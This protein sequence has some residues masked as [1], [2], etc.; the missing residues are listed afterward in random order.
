[1]SLS[2][3]R[4]RIVTRLGLTL[5]FIVV[6]TLSAVA[7][8]AKKL[9]DT[10]QLLTRL[11]QREWQVSVLAASWQGNAQ[12]ISARVSASMRLPAGA[13]RDSFLE[14]TEASD[15]AVQGL[16]KAL[17]PLV[18]DPLMRQRLA[19]A[20]LAS[21][22]FQ[23]IRA[24]LED[25][26]RTGEY[27]A[28]DSMLN[29][30]FEVRRK[31]YVEAIDQLRSRALESSQRATEQA[32]ADTQFAALVA[33]VW[34][35]FCVTSAGLAAWL[36][37]RS[38]KRP[39]LD[40]VSQAQAMAKGDLSGQPSLEFGGETGEVEAALHSMRLSLRDLVAQLKSSTDLV[41]LAIADASGHAVNAQQGH[42]DDAPGQ[43][44]VAAMASS[45]H[46]LQ[47]S[48]QT[49]AEI[50]WVKNNA[51]EVSRALQAK[52][53]E[54]SYGQA[55]VDRL[56]PVLQVPLAAFYLL[57]SASQQWQLMGRYGLN[58][59]D[60]QTLQIA[61]GEGPVGQCGRDRTAIDLDGLAPEH[62]RLR[63]ALLESV[64]RRV[65]LAPIIGRDGNSLAVLELGC[66]S[67]FG[68]REKSLLDELLPTVAMHLEILG[69]TRRTELLLKET[70]AQSAELAQQTEV[71][72][73]S[74]GKMRTQRDELATQT[75]ALLTQKNQL[76]AAN[77]AIEKKSLE[78]DAARAR[79]EEATNTK[80]M[81][82]AN[83]SHEIRTPMNAI[84]GMSH[85]CLKTDLAPRQRDYVNK[86]H[87]AGTSL[88]GIIND[89]LDFSK[90]EAG[91]FGLEELEF[92]LEDVLT[93]LSNLV[94]HTAHAKGL[95]LLIRVAPDVPQAF[96]GDPLRLG[97]VLTNLV[98][99]AVK[100]TAQ[101]QVKVDVSV[102]SRDGSRLQLRVSVSD[103]G[104]GM[105]EEQLSRL[106]QPFSQADGSTTRQFG[107][108]GLGL[109][110]AKRLV[111]LMG[112]DLTVSSVPGQGSE[113]VAQIWLG[114]SERQRGLRRQAVSSLRAL[115]VDDN[116]DARLI[117]S[118]NLV[119]L[120]MR[121][122][123]AASGAEALQKLKEA[124][125]IDPFRIAFIDWRMPD[126]DGVQTA[127]QIES[128]L[129]LQ[130]APK[131]VMVSAF[132]L[133]AFRDEGVAAGAQAVLSKP[134]NASQ[135]WDT[136]ANLISGHAGL[137]FNALPEASAPEW[138]FDG[139]RVL[140]V[141]D[142]EI[143][144]QIA[145]ELI[146]SVGAKVT[147]VGNGRLAVERLSAT[148]E[149]NAELPFD[150]VLMDLQMP[151]MDGH[152]ATKL[153]RQ[154]A[155]FD[156]LPI[157]AMTAHAM[158]EEQQRCLAEGMNDHITKPVDPQ[159]LYAALARWGGSRFRAAQE[160]SGQR[161]APAPGSAA[162]MP[163][164]FEQT[165]QR[166]EAAGVQ[167]QDAMQRLDGR[168]ELYQRVLRQFV[169]QQSDVLQQVARALD[170]GDLTGACRLAHTVK[171]LLAMLGAPELA[172]Q[173]LALEL[174]LSGPSADPQAAALLRAMEEPF[175][176]LLECIASALE[177]RPTSEPAPAQP[178]AQTGRSARLAL[179]A[180][181]EHDDAQAQELLEEQRQS[182]RHDL[183]SVFAQVA[184]HV[185]NFDFQSALR[186]LRA[187]P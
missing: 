1:M 96:V 105:S 124:D 183:G 115:V 93:H 27:M 55:L 75:Q 26:K 43:T 46:A 48:A 77:E 4:T 103:T 134:V 131:V 52:E 28:I 8:G 121:V 149:S 50:N 95:E 168:A 141:E 68:A 165:A 59:S 98:S 57:D 126:M 72:R 102:H 160:L 163:A 138:N 172:Q 167:V 60:A 174:A 156:Q 187:Q 9:Q 12:A 62:L 185:Q 24:Q 30:D 54:A 11:E 97:Q 180:L 33:L 92:W 22:E 58:L 42:E 110:I 158:V 85:L 89:I 127:R 84:I 44:D 3:S 64:P 39:L 63:S 144:Q 86:I 179:M 114:S 143:N 119:E 66:L 171:S 6:I 155:R 104:I 65:H 128:Q 175:E 136:V 49:I 38:I 159:S 101:G 41:T 15:T 170:A 148:H 34:V 137:R 29:G 69:R 120:G 146:E 5:A 182:L 83:M 181:L 151:E 186:V 37:A 70:R 17:A 177:M 53:D 150:L 139:L 111:Q 19:A 32:R 80:S 123:T 94:A 153:L 100:F 161:S 130:S 47:R 78:L 169:D 45:V 18:D 71:L 13:V 61:A 14:Q 147:A 176:V 23:R 152:Q 56:V 10:T 118:E 142:N 36:L 112:G 154:Q 135:L 178:D 90:I 107:G 76:E 113:F 87:A 166:L 133:D 164:D 25:L 31:A 67:D 88:L 79:A 125:A 35:F 81:F 74:E 132:G 109:T 116:V 145:V 122:D 99:N 21:A 2:L 51:A 16:M 40:V 117:L 162:A 73:W 108:T 91:R 7:F 20:Q 82:L 173:A 140:L 157:I 106:F 184:E 129:Q